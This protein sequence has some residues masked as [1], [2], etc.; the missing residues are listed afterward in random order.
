MLNWNCE[1]AY[2]FLFKFKYC[3]IKV[4][5]KEEAMEEDENIR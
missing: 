3:T 4:E 2:L 5:E 1:M